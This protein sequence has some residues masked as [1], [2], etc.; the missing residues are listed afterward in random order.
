MADINKKYRCVS[1]NQIHMKNV[2]VTF[3]NATIQAYLSNNS[4]SEEG[5]T[6]PL[7]LMSLVSLRRMQE[8]LCALVPE[9]LV[10]E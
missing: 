4:F 7:A 10:Y 5:K 6:L 8:Q 3:H 9:G 1:S 2:I